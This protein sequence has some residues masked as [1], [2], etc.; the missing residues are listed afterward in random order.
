MACKNICRLC[1]RLIISRSVTYA[2]G[3]LNIDIPSGNYSNGEKYCI[4][5]AQAIPDTATVN[6]L[7]YISIGG[8]GSYRLV[9][10]CCEHVVASALRTRTKYST[11]VVTDATGG[12]FKL[13]GNLSNETLNKKESLP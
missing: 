3:A 11:V 4:V 7:T 5:I 2:S 9:N 6:A 12:V 8:T 13:L 10:K 1:D